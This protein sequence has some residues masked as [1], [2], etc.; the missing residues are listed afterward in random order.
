MNQSN[1]QLQSRVTT[2]LRPPPTST[3]VYFSV[4]NYFHC[5][6]Y[7]E[8]IITPIR[9]VLSDE[10]IKLLSDIRDT[11]EPLTGVTDVLSDRSVTITQAEIA[12]NFALAHL[13][14]LDTGFAKKCS[15]M[16]KKRSEICDYGLNN[17]FFNF[18][19]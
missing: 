14:G 9:S 5:N 16:I 3:D 7:H 10:E 17:V 2:N 1:V 19:S 11:L 18:E 12:V 4:L 13:E 15:E 6:Q 8:Y